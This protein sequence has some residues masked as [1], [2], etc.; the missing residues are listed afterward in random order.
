MV[1]EISHEWR[2]E[3]IKSIW[4]FGE[5]VDKN[6]HTSKSKPTWPAD[7]KKELWAFSCLSWKQTDDYDLSRNSVVRAAHE[8][9]KSGCLNKFEGAK[10]AVAWEWLWCR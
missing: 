1:I 2:W 4:R 5:W 10:G 8:G 6:K 7:L 9:S 3:S